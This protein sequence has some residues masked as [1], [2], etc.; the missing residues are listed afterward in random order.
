MGDLGL[1]YFQD[2]DSYRNGVRFASAGGKPN[3]EFHVF[4]ENGIGHIFVFDQAI[5]ELNKCS[6]RRHGAENGGRGDA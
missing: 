6:L 2:L 1:L 5:D 3:A 4:G